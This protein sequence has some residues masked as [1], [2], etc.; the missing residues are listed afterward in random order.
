MHWANP[1]ILASRVRSSF[2][3]GCMNLAGTIAEVEVP[4]IVGFIV[5]GTGSYV[6]ATGSIGLGDLVRRRISSPS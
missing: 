5:E 2:L 1:S 3:G 6:L 4:V